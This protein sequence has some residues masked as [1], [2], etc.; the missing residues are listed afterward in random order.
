VSNS[1]QVLE[2]VTAFKQLSISCKEF[3]L[4]NKEPVLPKTLGDKQELKEIPKMNFLKRKK[5]KCSMDSSNSLSTSNSSMSVNLP[6]G[7]EATDIYGIRAFESTPSVLE[8]SKELDIPV[9]SPKCK[10]SPYLRKDVVW[11]SLLRAMKK[12]Y[13]KE[14]REYFNYSDPKFIRRG[15][16]KQ[17]A[18]TH[19][20]QFLEQSFTFEAPKNTAHFLFAL[21]DIKGRLYEENAAFPQL[22]R[23]IKDLLRSFTSKKLK[24]LL[25]FH[26]FS[27]LILHFLVQNS[28]I[29][30]LISKSKGDEMTKDAFQRYTVSLR[31]LVESYL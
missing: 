5:Q 23:D 15:D 9:L 6:D 21:V 18:F 25:R 30:E 24:D 7:A 19:A 2:A 12:Y 20:K 1:S 29:S 13:S 17:M 11:K 3:K 31:T 22:E 27:S 10:A 4:D 28:E 26:Q 14:F 16:L 8:E